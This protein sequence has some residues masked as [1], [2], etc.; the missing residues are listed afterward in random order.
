MKNLF[1]ED[2]IAYSPFCAYPSTTGP[3]EI[4]TNLSG[5]FSLT[6]PKKELKIKQ[7]IFQRSYTIVLW[8]DGDKTIVKCSE[9]DFD[10]EKG[11][12]MAIAKKIMTRNDFKRLIKNAIIQDK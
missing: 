6:M 4:R 1:E 3:I 2:K 9:E 12:A 11:L 8:E 7:V 10:K 5:G